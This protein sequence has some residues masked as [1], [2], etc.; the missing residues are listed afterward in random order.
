MPI[1]NAGNSVSATVAGDQTITI[2]VNHNSSGRVNFVSAEGGGLAVAGGGG[3]SFGPQATSQTFGPYGVTGTVTIFADAGSV[4]YTINP[5]TFQNI[6]VVSDI[7]ATG[8]GSKSIQASGSSNVVLGA[9]GTGTTQITRVNLLTVVSTDTSGTPGNATS[10]N[11][12][13]RAAIAS[14][15]QT[16]VITSTAVTAASKVL[17]SLGGTDAALT[18]VRVTPAAG[19][20]TVTGNAAATSNVPFDFLVVN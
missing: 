10:N 12:S 3:R 13:G 1:L 20:F 2:V 6:T 19:S 4:D 15:A 8:A 11:L 7:V 14:G 18:S 9:T 17:V 16:C 5:S